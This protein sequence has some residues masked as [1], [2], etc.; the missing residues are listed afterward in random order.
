MDPVIVKSD[1]FTRLR[2]LEARAKDLN[3]QGIDIQ[4]IIVPCLSV[5]ELLTEDDLIKVFSAGF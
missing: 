1:S 5:D 2:S 3:A 4:T